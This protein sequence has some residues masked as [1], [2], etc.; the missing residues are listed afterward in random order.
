MPGS[1]A[2]WFLGNLLQD[3]SIATLRVSVE[4]SSQ[5]AQ[6]QHGLAHGANATMVLATTEHRMLLRLEDGLDGT[7]QLYYVDDR[8]QRLW[9]RSQP[10]QAARI[11]ANG[12]VILWSGARLSRMRGSDGR[13]LWSQHLLDWHAFGTAA[14]VNLAEVVDDQLDLAVSLVHQ[15]ATGSAGSAASYFVALDPV[16]GAVRFQNRSPVPLAPGRCGPMILADSSVLAWTD[17]STDPVA[18][19]LRVERRRRSDGELEW[20]RE[21]RPTRIDDACASGASGNH[22]YIAAS[23]GEFLRIDALDAPSGEVRWQQ[24]LPRSLHWQIRVHPSGDLMLSSWKSADSG[25]F[26]TLSRLDG[27]DGTQRW[28]RATTAAAWDLDGEQLTLALATGAQAQLQRWDASSGATLAQHSASLVAWRRAAHS[29]F[30][31]GGSTCH[32]HLEGRQS[33]QLSC[34]DN[35]DGGLQWTRSLAPQLPAEQLTDVKLVDLRAGKM[36]VDLLVETA[37]GTSGP[38]RRLLALRLA[39]GSTAWELPPFRADW[40]LTQD[41]DGGLYGHHLDCNGSAGCPDPVDHQARYAGADGALIWSR[42][43]AGSIHAA[44]ADTVLL[45]MLANGASYWRALD[46][47]SGADRWSRSPLGA[48]ARPAALITPGGHLVVKQEPITAGGLRIELDGLDP[49]SGSLR[50]SVRPSVSHTSM[51]LGT[52]TALEGEEVLLIGRRAHSV[53]G[54]SKIGP[55]LA[56][57]D[58]ASGA[59]RLESA[60]PVVAEDRR[61]ARAIRR[62]A[63]GVEWL[64]HTREFANSFQRTTIG[65]LPASAQE[66]AER[67]FASGRFRPKNGYDEIWPNAS[68]DDSSLIVEDWRGEI[69]GVSSPR[70]QRWLEATGPAADIRLELQGPPDVRAQGASTNVVVAVH[71]PLAVSGLRSGFT[72]VS[73]ALQARLDACIPAG[74]CSE[75]DADGDVMLSFAAAGTVLMRWEVFTEDYRPHAPPAHAAQGRFHVDLPF[76]LADPDFDNHTASVRLILGG[77]SIGFE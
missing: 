28:A 59:V 30:T 49:V 31:V 76:E 7:P 11:L 39:D 19:K 57:V 34:V 50:W 33:V 48:I 6:F 62:T 72:A 29:V 75:P 69:N 63:A 46:A 4:G 45:T 64:V 77:T 3:D 5:V 52:L 36:G 26:Q 9:A 54:L 20:A 61:T 73:G 41:G 1:G 67:Q 65:H 53:A 17:W 43:P 51:S 56:H 12:D 71:S 24:R 58:A 74:A 70:V 23:D 55:W 10:A 44:D 32:A 42:I 38:H 66:G 13:L 25:P 68:L 60:P 47:R 18:P 22:I 35:M 37:A 16:D 21:L 40:Q 27:R 15:T 14:M 8:G 2:A